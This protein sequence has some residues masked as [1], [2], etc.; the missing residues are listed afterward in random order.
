MRC[1]MTTEVVLLRAVQ[2]K[3]PVKDWR[4]LKASVKTGDNC[5][6]SVASPGL[7]ILKKGCNAVRARAQL[8]ARAGFS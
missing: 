3:G 1:K 8:V 2:G 7:L 6:V 5:K 4:R